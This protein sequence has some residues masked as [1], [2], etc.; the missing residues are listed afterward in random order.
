MKENKD[1]KYLSDTDRS[2]NGWNEKVVKLN[3]NEVFW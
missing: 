2:N 3:Q 1:L